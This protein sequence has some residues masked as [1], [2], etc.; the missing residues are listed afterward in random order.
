MPELPNQM[1]CGECVTVDPLTDEEDRCYLYEL[2][3]KVTEPGLLEVTCSRCG[4]S[5]V[6]MTTFMSRS[7]PTRES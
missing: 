6:Y 5:A 4:R 1:F 3:A 2:R 7:G